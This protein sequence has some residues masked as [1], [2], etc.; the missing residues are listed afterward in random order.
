MYSTNAVWTRQLYPHRRLS[1]GKRRECILGISAAV[2]ISTMV[3]Q[4]RRGQLSTEMSYE[5]PDSHTPFDS[6]RP[7]PVSFDMTDDS[8]V[9]SVRRMPISNYEDLPSSARGA[10]ESIKSVQKP[11]MV[12][13]ST[14]SEKPL[15]LDRGTSPLP[16]ECFDS[17]V[18]S[19]EGFGLASGLW[20]F[21]PTA[22]PEASPDEDLEEAIQSRQK[23]WLTEFEEEEDKEHLK[24]EAIHFKKLKQH[25]KVHSLIAFESV[26]VL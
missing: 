12:D 19:E 2:C 26:L 5:E 25:T 10:S 15:M 14:Q 3:A 20:Q 24:E 6:L 21:K 7:H 16:P 1:T 11:R 22:L 18:D 13:V 17:E 9:E 4:R 8:D 23:Q